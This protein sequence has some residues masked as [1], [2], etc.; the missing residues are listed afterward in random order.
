MNTDVTTA[1]VYPDSDGKPMADNTLQWDWM[2]KIVGELREMF[3][4]QQV[5]VAGDLLWC[6]TKGDPKTCQEWEDEGFAPRVVF[7]VR[8]PTKPPNEERQQLPEMV[9]FCDQRGVEELYIIDTRKCVVL[10]WVRTH[11][12]LRFT[13]TDT[14][15]ISPL[16]GVGFAHNFA[17]GVFTWKPDIVMTPA[18]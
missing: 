11:E 14:S 1:D 6:S 12:R 18:E 2:V 9:Q 3:A 17:N 8:S 5:F 7:F 4:G 13:H 16:L 10:A 15:F